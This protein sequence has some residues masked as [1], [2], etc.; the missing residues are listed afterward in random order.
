M[1][2]TLFNYASFM[3]EHVLPQVIDMH[4]VV[5]IVGSYVV[6]VLKDWIWL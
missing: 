1:N 4:V 6:L 3:C 2:F 5:S